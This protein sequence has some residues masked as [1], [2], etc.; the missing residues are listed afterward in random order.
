MWEHVELREIRVFLTLAEELH[1]GRSAERLGLTTSR[2]SQS[3]RELEHKLGGQLVHR[4][5]R[6]V[7]LT[8]LGDRLRERLEPVY[9]EL[10]R[11]LAQIHA[12]NGRVEGALRL[13]LL[14]PTAGEPH[15]STIIARFE[16]QFSR[17]EVQLSDIMF[18]DP[19]GPLRRGEIDLMATRLPLEQMDLVVGPVLTLEPRVLQVAREHPLAHRREISIEDIANYRVPPLDGFPAETVEAVIPHETP[20]GRP[21][22]RRHLRPIPRTSYDVEMLVARGAMVVPTVPSFAAY[23]GHPDV[24]Y[25]PISDMPPVA[26]A[27]VWRRRRTDARLR[28]FIRVT[29][30]VVDASGAPHTLGRLA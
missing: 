1:F 7:A 8:A 30:D 26:T 16:D 24:V 21:I 3:L 12:A 29:Q 2:V 25:V 17:C 15:L 9:R 18:D 11:V 19:Y 5:S 22:R 13:G 6:N 10:S 20:K 14:Y 27:L 23:C 28:E 4:T